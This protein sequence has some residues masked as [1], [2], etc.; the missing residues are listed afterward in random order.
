[1]SARAWLGSVPV[2]LAWRYAAH[3]AMVAIALANE[4]RAAPHLPD[5]VLDHVP[6]VAW[7]ARW[8]YWI[9]LALYAPI[10]IALWRADRRA[11]VRFLWIGGALSLVR[12]LCVPLTGLG[13]PHGEDLN[14]GASSSTL[15][16]AWIAIVN[17]ITALGS[18][19]PHVA[20]TKDLFFSGHASSTFLLWLT[21]R[22]RGALGVAALVGHVLVVGTVFLAH[23]HYAIDVVGAWAITY[24]VFAL[25]RELRPPRDDARVSRP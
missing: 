8:N 2:A 16:D 12:G 24:A 9:W 4:P 20:L 23:L 14:A 15:F 6:Y 19:A 25:A 10:A 22:G 7:V 13:P 17:P 11:F 21:C 3:A 18:D 5:L 1:M